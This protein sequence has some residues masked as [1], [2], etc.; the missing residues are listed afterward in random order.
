M[1]GRIFGVMLRAQARY[2][3][4]FLALAIL[5]AVALP[6]AN[7]QGLDSAE[8]FRMDRAG[9]LLAQSSFLA[10]M[11]PVL[12]LC[13]GVFLAVA[14][15]LPDVHWRW[16]YVLTLPIER[17]RMAALR[18]ATGL[19]LILPVGLVL[20]LS[21]MLAAAVANAPDVV[22]AYP[23]ALALRFIAAAASGF[24]VGSLGVLA[25]RKLWL[26][27][28]VFLLL[29]IANATGIHLG[30]QLADLIFLNPLSPL[31]ALAGQWLLFDV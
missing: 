26:V 28:G 21:G 9:L 27:P 16:V 15:W 14:T 25:G 17:G 7:L 29:V 5:I 10:G 22:R 13:T 31:H 3:A 6:L 19:T 20:W 18:L 30:F 2:V 11:Y 24:V 12:A 23:G 1:N 4:P 8:A